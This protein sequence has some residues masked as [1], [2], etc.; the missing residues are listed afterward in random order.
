LDAP[1][2]ETRYGAFRALREMNAQERI[3]AADPEVKAFSY[4]VLKTAGPTMIHVTHSRYPEIVLFGADQR[5]RPTLAVNA[6]SQILVTGA[7][8]DQISVSKFA[9][10]EPD[11]KRI[12][13]TR[14]DEVI[15]A[16]AD[17]GGTYPD[18]VQALEEAKKADVIDSRFE[19]DAL[20][21]AGRVYDPVDHDASALD[22]KK[23]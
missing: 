3:V 18:V 19:V 4:H 13:T 20:P 12:V 23:A 10:G 2:A 1:S 6:G 15:R 21:E 11:Q 9:V 14:V 7:G 5:F 17:L 8:T 16:I 22:S